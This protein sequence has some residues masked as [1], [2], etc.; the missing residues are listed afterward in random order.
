MLAR[1]LR[2]HRFAPVSVSSRTRERVRYVVA[3]QIDEHVALRAPTR[4]VVPS[5]H[6]PLRQ[7]SSS[8]SASGGNLG[9]QKLLFHSGEKSVWNRVYRQ[10]VDGVLQRRH[11]V[12]DYFFS[13]A[14]LEPAGRLDRVFTLA[15]SF[16]IELETHPESG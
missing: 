9:A 12:T 4:S 7:C 2:R 3:T 15:R 13:L 11:R 8:R 5:P 16:A 14:P 10:F 1:Y 6:A